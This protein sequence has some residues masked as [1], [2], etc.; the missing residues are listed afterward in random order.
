MTSPASCPSQLASAQADT[1]MPSCTCDTQMQLRQH[2]QLTWARVW[3][4]ETTTRA[5]RVGGGGGDIQLTCPLPSLSEISY[6]IPRSPRQGACASPPAMQDG[7]GKE[8]VKTDEGSFQAKG[9]DA[10]PR[11]QAGSQ[12]S[13]HTASRPRKSHS[14][15]EACGFHCNRQTGIHLT[16]G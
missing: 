6:L 14:R 10:D 7:E 4:A 13:S 1:A 16:N 5:S 11:R 3:R 9:P 2:I 15:W 8:A 12:P